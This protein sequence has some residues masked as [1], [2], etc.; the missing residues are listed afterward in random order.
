MVHRTLEIRA[1]YDVKGI[2]ERV[3]TSGSSEDLTAEDSEVLARVRA[4]P[5]SPP[6]R[7]IGDAAH[8]LGAREIAQSSFTLQNLGNVRLLYLC[9]NSPHKTLWSRRNPNSYQQFG[10][11]EIEHTSTVLPASSFSIFP[12][13]RSP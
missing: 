3:Q 11:R 12:S 5:T 4:S 8:T 10:M 9:A 2:N 13:K 7:E 6:S 1:Y